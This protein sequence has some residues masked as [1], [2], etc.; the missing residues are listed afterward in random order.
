MFLGTQLC[1]QVCQAGD[2]VS[3]MSYMHLLSEIAGKKM[4]NNI[5]VCAIFIYFLPRT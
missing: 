3:L 1:N 4:Y 2:T 5:H